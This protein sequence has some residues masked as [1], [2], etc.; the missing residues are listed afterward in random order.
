[1]S[2]KTNILEFLESQIDKIILGVIGLV[3]LVLLW[4]YVIGNPYGAKVRIDGRETSVNPG[5]IDRKLQQEAEKLLQDLE[6]P[7]ASDAFSIYDKALLADYTR[8][9][10]AAIPDLPSDLSIPYPGVGE[11]VIEDERLYAV[12]VIPALGDVQT[13]VVRGAAQVPLEEVTPGTP[14]QA[15]QT[16]LE[17]IDLVTVSAQLDL[18]R[19][20]NNFQL[21]F[22]GP[23]LKSSW[24]NNQLARPVLARLELQRRVQQE[25]GSFGEWHVVP[26]TKTDTY[27]K[28]L[29]QLPLHVDQMQFGVDVWMSQYQSN[30]VQLDILQPEPYLFGI[31]RVEWMP[32]AFLSETYELMEEQA[33]QE[34]RE[35]IEERRRMLEQR[36]DD[37]GERRTT[38]RPT[39]RI[40]GGGRDRGLEPETAR[41][42]R[43]ARRD[44]RTLRDVERDMERAMLRENAR[45]DSLREPVMVWV[46]DDTAQPGKTYQYR[47]RIGVF[48]P[49][50]GKDWFH[51]E[52]LAFK[53]QTVLWSDYS[54]ATDEIRIPKMLHVFPVDPL[55][56]TR[57]DG[58]KEIEGVK[59]E[60]AKYYMGQWQS[61]EF[62]VYPGQP[63]GYP[64]KDEPEEDNM[65]QTDGFGNIRMSPNP[66][67]VASQAQDTTVDYSSGMTMVDV[68]KEITWG[69]HMRRDDYYNMLYH[70]SMDALAQVGIGKSN[71]PDL[72]K[73]AYGDVQDAMEEEVQQRQRPM[74]RMRM[75]PGRGRN[76]DL[77]EPMGL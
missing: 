62:D 65:R 37:G 19:L 49:I 52:Q 76:L 67:G 23:G 40:R 51:E 28:L 33:R 69:A 3:S 71:W 39:P 36:Q 48:N 21:S 68:V 34:R 24:Q 15:V 14:Y 70:D 35:L 7:P 20:F 47:V 9:L 32:P 31:S 54:E 12:P 58:T 29:E 60:V 30:E 16:K 74:E 72:L 77:D 53:E 73:D 41:E 5:N 61:H 22:A 1:M 50:A 8:K 66:T 6:Q 38:R 25:D 75:P 11:A 55:T 42:R 57:D 17:D 59:V 45:L 64:V 18:E 13:A 63:V 44:E 4:M 10:Q 2:K 46:H 26:R 43:L 27:K 56:V